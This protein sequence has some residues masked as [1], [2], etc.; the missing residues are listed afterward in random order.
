MPKMS[1][2][3]LIKKI[4]KLDPFIQCIVLTG[5]PDEDIILDFAAPT[6]IDIVGIIGYDVTS[7]NIKKQII[8]LHFSLEGGKKY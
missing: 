6:I 7:E 4:K 1:G 3:D 5:F 8:C 2:V